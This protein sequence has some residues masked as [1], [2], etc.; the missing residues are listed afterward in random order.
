M[1]FVW[2]LYGQKP[3]K[4][5][6]MSGPTARCTSPVSLLLTLAKYMPGRPRRPEAS[7][8]LLQEG[9]HLVIVAAKRR[10]EMAEGGEEEGREEGG[11]GGEEEEE[12]EEGEEG[13]CPGRRSGANVIM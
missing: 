4:K 13:E 7:T 1:G 8:D 11:E 3:Y 6:T 9:D 5:L 10:S 12:E 2:V